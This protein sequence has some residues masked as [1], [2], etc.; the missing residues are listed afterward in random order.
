M[1]HGMYM[2]CVHGGRSRDILAS[3]GALPTSAGNICEA[4]AKNTRNGRKESQYINER[5]HHRKTGILA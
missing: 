3:S 2:S 5:H 4:G 1:A